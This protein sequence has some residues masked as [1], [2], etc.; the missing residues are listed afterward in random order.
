[1]FKL[2]CSVAAVAVAH[3]ALALPAHGEDKKFVK[4]NN[5]WA[6]EIEDVNPKLGGPIFIGTSQDMAKFWKD[7]S[8][9]GSPPD[10]DFAT[11]FVVVVLSRGGSLDIKATNTDGVMDVFGFG[12]KDIQPGM[13]YVVGSFPRDGVKKVNGKELK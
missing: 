4:P 5:Q 6:G 12:T 8:G 7:A 11:E 1:M 2:F 13:R 9:K 10:V 3:V